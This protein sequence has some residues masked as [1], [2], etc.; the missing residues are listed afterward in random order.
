LT[1]RNSKKRYAILGPARSG[2][3]LLYRLVKDLS[4]DYNQ[5]LGLSVEYFQFEVPG[6]KVFD[7]GQELIQKQGYF[8]DKDKEL[9]RRIDLLQKYNF[10]Y[11]VKCIPRHLTLA[12]ID[13]LLQNYKILFCE[14]R[15]RYDRFLSFCIA[16]ETEV[17]NNSSKTFEYA[18]D[19][20]FVTDNIL[21]FYTLHEKKWIWAKKQIKKHVSPNTIWYE[22]LIKDPGREISEK[23]DLKWSDHRSE[24]YTQMFKLKDRQQKEKMIDNLD[25]V[26]KYFLHN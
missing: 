25:Y 7:N 6:N 24:H 11:T 15:D 17:W 26:Q 14:R 10:Q 22:D 16:F 1:G 23:T 3:T 18:D 21:K 19:K 5:G 12:V 8:N 20:I 13:C 2:T 9:A 4:P